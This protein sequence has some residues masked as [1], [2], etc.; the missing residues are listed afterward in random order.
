M[1]D[2]FSA[3]DATVE[4]VLRKKVPA[5]IAG[6]SVAH[7]LFMMVGCTHPLLTSS[8]VVYP[9]ITATVDAISNWYEAE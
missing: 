8:P 7:L 1:N 4:A 5:G 9:I 2:R 3:H 6:T